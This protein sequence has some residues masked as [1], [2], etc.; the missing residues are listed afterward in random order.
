MRLMALVAVGVFLSLVPIMSGGSSDP[1]FASKV[2]TDLGMT[3]KLDSVYERINSTYKVIG[4]D[5]GNVSWSFNKIGKSDSGLIYSSGML[6]VE[7]EDKF[8]PAVGDR[9]ESELKTEIDLLNSTQKISGGQR[10]KA[11]EDAAYYSGDGL[12]DARTWDSYG[13]LLARSGHY[14]RS[15][16]YYNR[17]IKADPSI[18]ESWNNRGVAF[19]NLGEYKEAVASYDQALNLTPNSSVTWNDK[20][21][22]LYRL[23]KPLLAL[24]CFNRSI[25]QDPNALA[26]Y[27]KGVILLGQGKYSEAL[28]CYN[29]SVLLDP[30]NAEAWNNEG[31]SLAKLGRNESALSCFNHASTLNQK[32]GGAWANGGMVL[33]AMGFENKSQDAFSVAKAL[34]YSNSGTK[35]Y[36]QAQTLPPALL[37]ETKKSQGLSMGTVLLILISISFVL[38]QKKRRGFK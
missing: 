1:T 7:S 28:K 23:G 18:P 25:Q 16:F 37:D 19:R 26:W 30:Y 13:N 29:Q 36:F 8:S 4:H 31:V 27:N 35:I 6:V 38:V 11:L 14:D 34:G 17:S 5:E 3:V 2:V 22:S 12:I 10:K 33:H 15:L 24:E 20:G 21:E 32:F 9:L